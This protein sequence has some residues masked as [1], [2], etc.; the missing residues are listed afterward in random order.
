MRLW[1]PRSEVPE[2]QKRL[3]SEGFY[4]GPIDGKFGILTDQAVRAYQKA[5]PPLRID[6]IVGPKTRAVLNK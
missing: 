5:N 1:L 6:G 2:L 4:A 3:T